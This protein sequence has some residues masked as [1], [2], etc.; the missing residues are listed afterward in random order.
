[1]VS[2][3]FAPSKNSSINK[4]IICKIKYCHLEA[5]QSQLINV[6]CILNQAVLVLAKI[7]KKSLAFR[8]RKNGLRQDD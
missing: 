8:T 4:L 7:F 2:F 5:R 1:M 3:L 6:F